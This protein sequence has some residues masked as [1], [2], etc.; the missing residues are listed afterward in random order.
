MVEA[1]KKIMPQELVGQLSTVSVISENLFGALF[2]T[3]DYFGA[4]VFPS[5]EYGKAI[6]M[7]VAKINFDYIT[8]LH[9]E[10]FYN[11]ALDRLIYMQREMGKYPDYFNGTHRRILEALMATNERNLGGSTKRP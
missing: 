2:R 8:K 3:H 7:V 9:E 1:V 4:R 5:D 11:E 10:G 6:G